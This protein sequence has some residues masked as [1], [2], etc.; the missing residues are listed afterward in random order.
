MPS[1]AYWMDINFEEW[2]I[3]PACGSS[4]AV[5]V[6]DGTSLGFRKQL[7][8]MTSDRRIDQEIVQRKS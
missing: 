2:I 3:C 5:I 8:L 1:W 7:L 6:C 4:P